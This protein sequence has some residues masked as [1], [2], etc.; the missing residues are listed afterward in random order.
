MSFSS[1]RIDGREILN[2]LDE[3]KTWIY[4]HTHNKQCYTY[5]SGC[6]MICNPLGYP[7]EHYME[8]DSWSYKRN[9]KNFDKLKFITMPVGK[10]PSY[11]DIFKNIN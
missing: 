2:D 1:S 3:T 11:D 6:N 4:G 5:D 10:L 8:P 7:S 9:I